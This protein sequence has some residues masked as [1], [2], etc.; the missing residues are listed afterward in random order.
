MTFPRAE[1]ICVSVC[2]KEEKECKSVLEWIPACEARLFGHIHPS[3][4]I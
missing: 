1:I 3:D 2:G 4:G